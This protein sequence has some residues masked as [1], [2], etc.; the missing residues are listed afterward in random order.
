[1]ELIIFMANYCTENM[2]KLILKS[3]LSLLIPAMLTPVSLK[4]NEGMWLPL[5]I[6]KLE[7]KMQQMGSKLSAEDIYSVNNASI[8]DAIVSFGGF[9]TGEIVSSKGLVFTNHHCGYDAIAGLSSTENNWLKNGFWAKNHQSELPVAD[10]SV[11]I[12][13][14]MEDVTVKMKNAENPDKLKEELIAAAE[15]E[16][17]G[18]TAEVKSFFH[19]NEYYLS[20]YQTFSDI[21]LVGTP[22]ENI[23]KFGGDT[24]NWMWPR[25]TGDFSVFRIYAD[26]Q[27]NPAPFSQSN[28]PYVPKHHLPISL[29]G[30]KLND[31]S[32]I[33]GFPGRTRRYISSDQINKTIDV[34]YPERTAIMDV[35]LKAMKKYMDKD[36]AIKIKLA[37]NYA[38]YANTWKYY[39]GNM[40]SAKHS[41]FVQKK[42]DFQSELQEW[43]LADEARKAKW[44]TIIEDIATLQT[45]DMATN[46]LTNFLNFG[47]FG[48]GFVVNGFQFF[49]VSQGIKDTKT[50]SEAVQKSLD[51]IKAALPKLFKE[52][53]AEAD[54]EV[55]VEVTAYCMQ[56]LPKEDWPEMLRNEAFAKRKGKTDKEKIRSLADEIFKK[57]FLVDAGK[58]E[59]FLN[60]PSKKTLDKDPGFN[61]FKSVIQVYF[62]VVGSASSTRAKEE[63]LMKEYMSAI[64]A[65]RSKELLYPDANFTLRLTY[66]AVLP[67]V[68]NEGKEME[69]TTP[70]SEILAKASETNPEFEVF[71]ELR[72]LIEQR[73]YGQY[74]QNGEDLVVN[75]ITNHDITGG[76]SGSPVINAE[77]HLIGI[78]FDGNWESMVGDLSYQEKTQRTISVDI[79]YVL[80]IIE[81]YAGANHLIDELTLI[82]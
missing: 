66:G 35:K 55:F 61:Y 30:V 76:N 41:D 10:L 44:G 28:V 64:M 34:D 7:S 80:F 48:P 29:K 46:K 69:F 47:Y 26:A 2:R 79:R 21:R 43:I 6:K 15:A 75:F 11:N 19:G 3:F 59:K 82:K 40:Y 27:N 32:F 54:K 73:N 68:N 51:E 65:Y 20:V 50:Q 62:K 70:A 25:H 77:G 17:K 71:P 4:A 78:A 9:C 31:F 63:E 60:K 8:K 16:G 24:D 39:L 53:S 36:E 58:M 23:G 14:R 81:K 49:Q 74:A 56:N 45:A 38:S 67:Y 22:P 33:M 37:S 5:Y 13:V 42:M 1:M 52:Y 72:Q 12:L 18:Y 57:S